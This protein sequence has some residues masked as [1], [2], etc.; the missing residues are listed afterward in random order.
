MT[1]ASDHGFLYRIPVHISIGG[2]NDVAWV[3]RA[4]P[5]LWP[6]PGLP[7]FLSLTEEALLPAPAAYFNVDGDSLEL[8]TKA[9]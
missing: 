2:I 8:S 7:G 9:K 4:S 6:A 3:A 5:M 1:K